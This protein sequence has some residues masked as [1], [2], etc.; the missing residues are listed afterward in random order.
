MAYSVVINSA[1]ILL[2]ST[3]LSPAIRQD[4]LDTLLFAQLAADEDFPGVN[5]Y[6]QWTDVLADTLGACGW[7]YHDQGT[8]S[9]IIPAAGVKSLSIHEAI[10]AAFQSRLTAEQIVLITNALHR[11]AQLPEKSAAAVV[12]RGQSILAVETNA[13]S[14]GGNDSGSSAHRVR[15]LA[16]V[17]EADGFLTLA[18][19]FFETDQPI[20]SQFLGQDFA[21]GNSMGRVST[22]FFHCRLS[23]DE[24]MPFRENTVLW[25]GPQRQALCISLLPQFAR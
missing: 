14:M 13:A 19:V 6:S 9:G 1:S 8:T 10:L 22:S 23:V 25:L 24:Y 4:A 21:L 15:V 12:L 11:V 2:L 7:K 18:S 20:E 17:I 3:A 5:N 16:G